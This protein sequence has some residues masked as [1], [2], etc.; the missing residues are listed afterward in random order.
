MTRQLTVEWPDPAAFAARDGAP[1][2]LLAVSDAP[3]PALEY[4]VNR[5]ALGRLDGIVGCGD[6]EPAYLCFL[7]DAFRVPL[8]FVRGNHDRD[9]QWQSMSEEA[10]TPIASGRLTE[11]GGVTIAA[12]SWPGLGRD[13]V[14]L[15]NE[16]SAWWDVL[17]A[18]RRLFIR[19]L[20]RGRRPVLIVSHAPPRGVGDT[21]SD[22][23]HLGY[24][25]Y[26]WLLDRLHPPL[27]LHGHTTI[28]TVKDWRDTH[29]PT[30]VANVTGSVVVELV[31]P[32]ASP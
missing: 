11:L 28:A 21:A 2:R 27:W 13:H 9:G 7:A 29:G 16:R 23:Y 22:P 31:P 10:P 17:R 4:E 25:A 18:A 5:Q 6:L 12:F 26:R 20:V 8:A 15:R 3:D 14:A 1:I 32:T 30:T 24:N 19:R